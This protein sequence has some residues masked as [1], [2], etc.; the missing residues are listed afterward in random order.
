[1]LFI[2]VIGSNDGDNTATFIIL[3]CTQF[4][5]ARYS[6]IAPRQTR[7]DIHLNRS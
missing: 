4:C 7:R 1:M 3:F 5:S 2:V 6:H